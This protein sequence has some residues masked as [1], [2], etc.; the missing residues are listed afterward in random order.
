MERENEIVDGVGN[1]TGELSQGIELRSDA[2]A[3]L[4][5][6]AG[7]Q[8]V[9]RGGKQYGKRCRMTVSGND[10]SVEIQRD[11]FLLLPELHFGRQNGSNEFVEL[12]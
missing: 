7:E 1:F 12:R 4:E 10:V 3:M 8:H 6:D 11:K 2:G 9:G 5:D